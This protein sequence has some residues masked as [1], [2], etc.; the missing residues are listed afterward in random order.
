MT[1]TRSKM[2][3]L[4]W[5]SIVSNMLHSTIHEH[6]QAWVLCYTSRTESYRN[7]LSIFGGILSLTKI[8][9]WYTQK[10]SKTHHAPINHKKIFLLPAAF[11]H[12]LFNT[13]VLNTNHEPDNLLDSEYVGKTK[14]IRFFANNQEL[15]E[16]M[17]TF[18]VF[19]LYN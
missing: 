4:L 16:T 6:P 3:H 13:N 2:T 1:A 12:R 8:K 5:L 19:R 11:T 18:L 7:T 14:L 10:F 17:S 9:R 15:Q